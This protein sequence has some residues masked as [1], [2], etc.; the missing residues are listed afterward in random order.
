MRH[1]ILLTIAILTATVRA[2]TVVGKIGDIEIKSTELRE[3]LA[4]LEAGQEAALAKDPAAIGQYV[5]ALLVQR[6][7][8]KQATDSHFD[9]DPAVIARL[10]RARETALTEAY[11]E[12]FTQPSADYPGDAEIQAAYTAA[13]DTLLIPKT[14]RLAQIFVKDEAKLKAV[15]QQLNAKGA[16]FA[17]I[18]TA[19]SEEAKSAANRGEIGWL[20]EAQIQ[21]E[22]KDRVLKLAVGGVSAPIKLNDGYHLLKLLDTREA[23]TATLDQ[24]RPQLVARLRQEK[25]KQLRQEHL[26][27]L[28]KENPLAINEIELTKLLSPGGN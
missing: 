7:L 27:T 11:L 18:A 16:D 22:I 12:T 8:L 9:Q 3:S 17:A 1:P 23:A 21:P 13:K 15:T 4:G 24:I 25:S 28:L 14:Y 2:E 19:Q 26:A 10:V 20:A 6:L 5:R